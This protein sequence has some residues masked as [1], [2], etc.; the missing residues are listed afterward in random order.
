MD[1]DEKT[2]ADAM[3][4]KM[5]IPVPN[6]A[7]KPSRRQHE[8]VILPVPKPRPLKKEESSSDSASSES[9]SETSSEEEEKFHA[10]QRYTKQKPLTLRPEQIH[11]IREPEHF[12]NKK[13]VVKTKK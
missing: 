5:D 10:V 3:L 13:V 7:V 1:V 4:K 2:L 8:P 9:E 12:Q 6:F 11:R